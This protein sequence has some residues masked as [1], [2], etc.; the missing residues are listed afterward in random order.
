MF[1]LLP[2]YVLLCYDT[3]QKIHDSDSYR[4]VHELSDINNLM[5]DVFGFESMENIWNYPYPIS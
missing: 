5:I 2:Y 3:A 1:S 4:H